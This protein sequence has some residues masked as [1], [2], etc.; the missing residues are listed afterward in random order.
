MVDLD[1]EE[2]DAEDKTR[3][4]KPSKTSE[5]WDHFTMDERNDPND[6]KVVCNYCEKDYACNTKTCETSSIWVHLKKQCNKYLFRV[7]DKRQKL[8]SFSIKNETGSE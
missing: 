2:E 3:K 1:E 5:I 8:L 7:E 4:R 6:P